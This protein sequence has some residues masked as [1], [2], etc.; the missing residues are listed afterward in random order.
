MSG[1]GG[2]DAPHIEG[3]R[4][5]F[6]SN[7]SQ[8]PGQE[9]SAPSSP[10][11]PARGR[12]GGRNTRGSRPRGGFRG[13]MDASNNTP[14]PGMNGGPRWN[15]VKERIV[16]SESEAKDT[17]TNGLPEPADDADAEICFICASQV[18]HNAIAPCNHRTCHIC[19]LRLRA[20][21]KTK[22]CAHCRT[23]SDFVIF[24][25]D[26]SKRY[27]DFKEEDFAN[28]DE[29]LGVKYEKQDIHQD[30]VLL[31]RFNCPDPSCDVACFGW[32]DLHRHVRSIHHKVMC[33]LCTRNKKVF[34]HEH[35]LFTYPELRKH[36][37]FGD[38]NPGAVDQSGFRGHPEC[39]FCKQRFYGDDEL[40]T[41]CRDRHERCH[42]CDRRNPGRQQQYFV[43]YNALEVHFRTDHFLCLEQECL[44][45][46]FVV[47]E[48]EMDLKAHQLDV[49]PNVLS[50]D[51]R[52]DARRIDMSSFDY[53]SPHSS[54]RR[55]DGRDRRRGGGGGGGGRGRDPNA[56]PL[57]VSTAQP[58]RRDE[59]AFQRQREIQSA[60]SVS[61]RTFGGNLTSSTPRPPEPVE[62][63]APQTTTVTA[64][65]PTSNHTSRA[66]PPIGSLSLN[67]GPSY[68]SAGQPISISGPTTDNDPQSQARRARHAAVM[69]RALRLLKHDQSKMDEFRAKVGSY[70]NGSISASDAIDSFYS[71]FDTGTVE[72]GK[73]V[74]E[75]A[76]IYESQA[77]RLGLLGAWNDWKAT[78]E[79]YPGLPAA[80]G[81]SN[82][83][84]GGGGTRLLRL[85]SSTAQSSK[86]PVSRQGSWRSSSGP[87]E[88][89]PALAQAA[90]SSST[91]TNRSRPAPAN[92]PHWSG[93]ATSSQPSSRPTSRPPVS[94]P[95]AA[96][97]TDAFPALPTTAKPSTTI[98]GYRTPGIK[99]NL[100]PA[101]TSNAWDAG[102]S[103]ADAA[104]GPGDPNSTTD[105]EDTK[106]KKSKAPKKQLLFHF[107]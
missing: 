85:K 100:G 48:S 92:G 93:A 78:R 50:K 13:G 14:P 46:K 94:R 95:A 70:Q 9:S 87:S 32:P 101:P 23:L 41:H 59:L 6:P 82:S 68:A 63:Q 105:S 83:V 33:D 66:F 35:E 76:E 25:D 67:N 11:R 96:A 57:P 26:G 77:K 15:P 51:A 54:E 21:Y 60:Q 28:V 27:E 16:G 55:G 86:S 31:L 74:Q 84:L 47:F 56:E 36:E 62:R 45:K 43:D 12:R 17:E 22:A 39:G 42:I 81:S 52:R 98:S 1:T 2:A 80:A 71:L 18:V 104:G 30:T 97:P 107:G 88:S 91:S 103:G 65:R 106:K 34:T 58:L 10:A 73:L 102:P 8:T 19:A 72:L 75:L 7:A 69:E 24:T 64:P 89:F 53:R 40:Y 38:D 29:N 99:R 79:E 44:E 90:G 20:L 5:H 49:H 3:Q 61:T 4:R 37:K